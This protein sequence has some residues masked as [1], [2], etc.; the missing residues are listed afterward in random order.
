MDFVYIHFDIYNQRSIYFKD[1]NGQ[2]VG[3]VVKTSIVYTHDNWSNTKIVVKDNTIKC[4]IDDT[5]LISESL[6]S[7]TTVDLSKS[8]NGFGIGAA[9]GGATAS[10]KIKN[11]S[12]K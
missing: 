7:F 9:T 3:S 8:Y 10:H 12:F 2:L 1:G 4:F 11:I 5:L 6:E